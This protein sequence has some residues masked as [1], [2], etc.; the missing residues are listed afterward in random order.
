MEK[1]INN[2]KLIYELSV[3]DILTVIEEEDIN[4]IENFIG[5]EI[6]WKGTISNALV[7]LQSNR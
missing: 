5:Q 6:D 7:R 1:S 3:Q 4:F 2:D